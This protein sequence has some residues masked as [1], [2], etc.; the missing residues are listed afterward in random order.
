MS[1]ILH[2]LG[3]K[4]NTDKSFIHNFCN[5]YE[6]ILQKFNREDPIRLL[7]IG[8]AH[9]C[10]IK[11]WREYFPNAEIHCIDITENPIPEMS[12]VVYHKINCD[13]IENIDV[14]AD[15]IENFDIIIDDGGHTMKQ[16]Q[17]A[18]KALWCKV[19]PGGLF[20]M[21]DLHTSI[22]E[23]HGDKYNKE[24]QP[25]TYEMIN[26]LINKTHFESVYITFKEFQILA[27]TISKAE[28]FWA[29]PRSITSYVLK[30]NTDSF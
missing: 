16:Q 27:K 4:Y 12:N 30:A 29:K 5:F 13:H 11:M 15:N 22:K 7:E 1:G 9:G 19:N 21:E 23:F 6:T 24:N 26:A 25:T 20:I 17:N 28:I 14:F 18:F 2:N 8:T 10:S 3:L